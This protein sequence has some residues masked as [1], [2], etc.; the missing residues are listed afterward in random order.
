MVKNEE[1]ALDPLDL[2][3][4]LID[5]AVSTDRALD[6]AFWLRATADTITAEPSQEHQTLFMIA[7]RRI[8][9]TYRVSKN[10]RNAA[11]RRLA[12]MVRPIA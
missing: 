6:S 2:V 4:R 5:L 3:R 9:G 7:V 11:T 10:R 1:E 12:A 8:H